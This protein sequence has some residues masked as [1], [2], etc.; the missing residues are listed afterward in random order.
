MIENDTKVNRPSIPMFFFFLCF[1]NPMFQRGPCGILFLRFS[2]LSVFSILCFKGIL[3]VHSI[4]YVFFI[5]L[6]FNP[7]IQMWPKT[8]ENRLSVSVDSD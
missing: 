6:F 8:C 5:S 3:S 2:H 1:L 4:S 7:A